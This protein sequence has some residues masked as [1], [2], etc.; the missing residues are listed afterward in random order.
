MSL[1]NVSGLGQ[2]PISLVSHGRDPSDKWLR[3]N[4][5]AQGRAGAVTQPGGS[6]IS[7]K[8]DRL[9]DE[10]LRRRTAK[11]DPPLPRRA[12]VTDFWDCIL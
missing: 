4:V 1:G 6:L 11:L 9:P 8:P 10:L 7:S 2:T 12:A 5:L 3:Q